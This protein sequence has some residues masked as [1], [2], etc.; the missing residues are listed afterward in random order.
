MYISFPHLLHFKYLCSSQRF[1]ESFLPP[2]FRGTKNPT[3][4]TGS[5]GW[6]GSPWKIRE[7]WALAASSWSNTFPMTVLGEHLGQILL[8]YNFWTVPNYWS[9]F[10]CFTQKI[11]PAFHTLKCGAQCKAS[12]CPVW[13]LN[14]KQWNLINV[15]DLKFFDDFKW[16]EAKHISDWS[17]SPSNCSF[18]RHFLAIAILCSWLLITKS[19]SQI[20][21]PDVQSEMHGSTFYAWSTCIICYVRATGFTIL[22][23]ICSETKNDIETNSHRLI[24]PG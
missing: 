11:H 7:I 13:K 3:P 19:T 14:L 1:G 24:L 15:G 23:Q 21:I 12:L 8:R 22:K 4:P 6:A 5:N 16:L 18:A 10:S 17:S 9:F 20:C 2:I